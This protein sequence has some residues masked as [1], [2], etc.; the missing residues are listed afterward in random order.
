MDIYFYYVKH[1][2]LQVKHWV[3]VFNLQIIHGKSLRNNY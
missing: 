1:L 3:K 2:R